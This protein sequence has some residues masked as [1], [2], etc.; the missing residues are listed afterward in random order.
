MSN[1]PQNITRSSLTGVVIIVL[2]VLI[3][4]FPILDGPFKVIYDS[5]H[6]VNNVLLSDPNNIV[7]ILSGNMF[8]VDAPYRPA[9]LLS[10]MAERHSFGSIPLYYYLVNILLHAVCALLAYAVMTLAFKD[11][12]LGLLTALIFAIHPAHWEAVSFLSGRA[13]LLN[14]FFVLVSLSTC[15]LYM[16]RLN[17]WWMFISLTSFIG[18]LLSHEAYG[19]NIAVFIFYI[20]YMIRNEQSIGLRWLIFLPYAVVSIMFVVIRN[21]LGGFHFIFS[22]D[23]MD[24]AIRL[25]SAL[26]SLVL[27]T[28]VLIAPVQMYFHQSAKPLQGL[29]DPTALVAVV[30]AA[31]GFV[32]LMI[33]RKRASDVVLFLM[34]WFIFSSWPLMKSAFDLGAGPGRLPIDGTISYLASVPFIALIVLGVRKLLAL[35]PKRGLWGMA[36]FGVVAAVFFLLMFRQNILST[37]E[38]AILKDAKK[39]EPSSPIIEYNLGIIYAQQD[40]Y[41]E[42]QNHFERAVQLDPNLT[43]ARMG[44]GKI[45]YEQGKFL[46]AAKAYEAVNNPGRY[47]AILRN[48]LRSIYNA[49]VASQ[50]V[51]LRSDPQ[52]INAYFSLGVFYEKLGDANRAIAAYQQVMEL[53]P[54]NASGLKGIALRFQGLLYQK[55]GLTEKAQENFAQVH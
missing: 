26:R 7:K 34:V 31:M 51:I 12:I 32:F 53:D 35:I 36:L 6:I 38:I 45:L 15:M 11:R 25:L 20:F 24:W 44:L 1:L 37:D 48:N 47:E 19:S 5:D 10:H 2:F 50:E 29:S 30:L 54:D 39:Y 43:S 55:L 18:A 42:S 23:M 22:T 27:E 8:R 28:S 16:R 3:S 17:G 4:Y 40:L 52:N 41:P 13:V 46:D 21:G 49:L 14:T 33:R 9:T